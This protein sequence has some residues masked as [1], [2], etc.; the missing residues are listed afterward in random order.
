VELELQAVVICYMGLGIEPGSFGRS[1]GALNCFFFFFFL[2][3]FIYL[4]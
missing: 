3:I 4:F 2:E 1:A